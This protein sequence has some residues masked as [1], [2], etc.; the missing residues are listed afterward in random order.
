MAVDFIDIV[1]DEDHVSKQPEEEPHKHSA[2][3][4]SCFMNSNVCFNS[5][6][7]L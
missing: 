6:H 3:S 2:V 7:D 4:T 5:I 1:K